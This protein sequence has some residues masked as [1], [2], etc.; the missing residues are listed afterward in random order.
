V[1]VSNPPEKMDKTH[2]ALEFATKKHSGQKRRGGEDYVQ[3]CIRVSKTV[4]FFTGNENVIIAALL[5]DTLEDTET[6]FDELNAEFGA[7][8]ANLVLS[9]T[10]DEEKMLKMGGK[11]EY[12]AKKIT[13]LSDDALIIKM[14]DRLDNIAD[15]GDNVWSHRYCEQTRHVFLQSL[16]KEKLNGVHLELLDMIRIR[17]ENCENLCKANI[18]AK[19]YSTNTQ[20]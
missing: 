6:T 2:K 10:N 9:V 3:H 12:M 15:L 20:K 11:R 19:M 14:A 17:V 18:F 16:N 13:T 5:H 1:R 8:V 4:S 7:E